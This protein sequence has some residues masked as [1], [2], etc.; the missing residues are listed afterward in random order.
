M[1]GGIGRRHASLRWVFER[2]LTRFGPQRWWPADTPF[3]ICVGAILVQGTSWRNAELALDALR[4]TDR[5]RFERL[6]ELGSGQLARLIRPP[7]V[8]F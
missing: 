7:M 8:P 4:R 3:E 1:G 6:R 2:L 5:L